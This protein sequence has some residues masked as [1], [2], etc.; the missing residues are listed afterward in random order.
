VERANRLKKKEDKSSK[1][2]NKDSLLLEELEPGWIHTFLCQPLLSYLLPTLPVLGLTF[3]DAIHLV[4]NLTENVIKLC[5]QR[6]WGRRTSTRQR[7]RSIV[8]HIERFLTYH[9]HAVHLP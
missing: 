2:P 5:G 7:L 3:I 4:E 9:E 8:P 1:T 6:G